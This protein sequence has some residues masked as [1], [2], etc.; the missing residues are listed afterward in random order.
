MSEAVSIKRYLMFYEVLISIIAIDKFE[1]IPEI[2]FF[3][4][5]SRKYI[6]FQLCCS[7]PSI[8]LSSILSHI[9]DKNEYTQCHVLC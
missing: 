2:I 9:S 5:G 8:I 3:N 4:I 6:K 1:S 7:G